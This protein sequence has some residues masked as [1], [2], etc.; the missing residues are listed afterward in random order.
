VFIKKKKKINDSPNFSSKK[1][2]QTFNRFVINE[3]SSSDSFPFC[4]SS[5]KRTRTLEGVSFGVSF[6]VSSCVS[7]PSS[8]LPKEEP[9]EKRLR[10]GLLPVEVGV[11]QLPRNDSKKKKKKKN[12]N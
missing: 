7:S 11:T 3:T 2:S 4:E 10:E 6:D 1:K 9:N 12:K 5:N 8:T